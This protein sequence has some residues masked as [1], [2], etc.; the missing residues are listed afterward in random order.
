MA[1]IFP[2]AIENL[3]PVEIS[4]IINCQL[5]EKEKFDVVIIELDWFFSKFKRENKIFEEELGVDI[6]DIE[7]SCFPIDF[8]P[9]S[10]D[11]IYELH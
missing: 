3:L 4:R 11:N 7:C 2:I 1:S 6:T 9:F 8:K 5:F 10:L